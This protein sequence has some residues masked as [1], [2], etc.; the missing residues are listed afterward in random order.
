MEPE[1]TVTNKKV[2]PSP[3]YPLA[4]QPVRKQRAPQ[5]GQQKGTCFM[6][7]RI[8]QL[9]HPFFSCIDLLSRGP[10]S[11]GESVRDPGQRV[12]T[13]HTT[14]LWRWGQVPLKVPS[15]VPLPSLGAVSDFSLPAEGQ[16]SQPSGQSAAVWNSAQVSIPASFPAAVIHALAR[17]PPGRGWDK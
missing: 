4:S 16:Q 11:S 13:W 14:Q 9:H 7:R 12:V 2:Q 8:Q 5:S 6:F 10:G 1:D 17:L 15:Q 3:R